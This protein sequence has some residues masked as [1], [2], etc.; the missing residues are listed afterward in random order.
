MSYQFDYIN[1]KCNNYLSIWE[2]G[3]N[4]PKYDPITKEW[5]FM[6]SNGH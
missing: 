4:A 2:Q 3:I 5:Q 6:Y 1:G